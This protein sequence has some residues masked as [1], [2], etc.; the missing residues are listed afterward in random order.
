M[1]APPFASAAEAREAA[2]GRACQGVSFVEGEEA[3]NAFAKAARVL[4]RRWTALGLAVSQSWGGN[5]SE[6]KAESLLEEVFQL[7]EERGSAVTEQELGQL[8]LEAMEEDFNAQLEDGS[9]EQVAHELVMLHADC[10][11]KELSRPQRIIAG[12]NNPSQ[13]APGVAQSREEGQEDASM[14]DDE[15]AE[16][17]RGDSGSMNEPQVDEDGFQVVTR[18]RKKGPPR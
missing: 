13:V 4:F 14:G 9:A 3:A 17:G 7:F 2:L 16:E 15:P 1:A 6:Q 18:G 11:N 8:L 10:V 5:D 12:D